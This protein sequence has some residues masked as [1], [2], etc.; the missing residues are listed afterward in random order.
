MVLVSNNHVLQLALLSQI[1]YA[2]ARRE[3]E[4]IENFYVSP[5]PRF[6]RLCVKI[7]YSKIR[8]EV[9]GQMRQKAQ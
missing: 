1:A 6:L 4:R 2:E 8:E 5:Y 9:S 3:E 7:S